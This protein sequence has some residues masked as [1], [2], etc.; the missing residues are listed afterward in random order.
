MIQLQELRI[1]YQCELLSSEH[2]LLEAGKVYALVGRNGIG[3][4]TLIQT[5]A[6]LQ[7]S[8]F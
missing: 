4:S 3:K 7:K 6:G 5:M 8:R 2:L 1:G